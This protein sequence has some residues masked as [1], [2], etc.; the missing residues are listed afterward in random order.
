MHT[1]AALEPGTPLPV[2]RV[3]SLDS[4]NAVAQ[5]RRCLTPAVL[6]HVHNLMC[7]P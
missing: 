1:I 6:T 7:L 2:Q 4:S 5:P 3:T